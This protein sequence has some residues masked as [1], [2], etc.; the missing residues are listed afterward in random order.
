MTFLGSF[1][2]LKPW[3]ELGESSAGYKHE[4]F[5]VYELHRKGCL[6]HVVEFFVLSP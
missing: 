2:I 3:N 6:V 4:V 5:S 1:K